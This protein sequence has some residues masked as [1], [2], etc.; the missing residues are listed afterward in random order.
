MI[1]LYIDV[2]NKYKNTDEF[3]KKCILNDKDWI[4][5]FGK[6]DCGELKIKRGPGGQPIL[7]D[8]N[9][10]VSHTA[11]M[12]LLAVSDIGAIGIDAENVTRSNFDVGKA[13]KL[14][15]RYFNKDE[16]E[17]ICD[18]FEKSGLEKKEKQVEKIQNENLNNQIEDFDTGKSEENITV[19]FL[20]I[21][22]RKEALLKLRGIGLKGGLKIVKDSDTSVDTFF[23]DYNH[24][25]KKEK[26]IVSLAL[27]K[28]QGSFSIP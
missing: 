21:W 25:E 27:N 14:A 18:G 9:I 5:I 4:Q 6:T 1:K 20:K 26:L 19:R 7:D 22:T 8:L 11:E 12:I 13:R 23:Y 17:Y 2:K 3:I 24:D 28:S 15:K 10:S 16:L